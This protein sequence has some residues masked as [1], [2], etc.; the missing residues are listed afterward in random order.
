MLADAEVQ[1]HQPTQMHSDCGGCLGSVWN[2][3]ILC[4][5]GIALTDVI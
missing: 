5:N 2:A 1:P 4:M 3:P